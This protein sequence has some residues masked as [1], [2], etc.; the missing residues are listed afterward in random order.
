VSAGLVTAFAAQSRPQWPPAVQSVPDDSPSLSPDAEMRTFFLPPGYRVELVASEPMVEEPVLID[1]DPRGRMWVVEMLGYMQDMPATSEREPSGRISVLEDTNGDGRMDRKTVF[2][3]GL[4]LPRALK[5]LDRGVLVGEPPHLWLARD[6]NGD[7]KADQKDL[8]CD[9]YGT[10]LANVEHNL[11]GLLWAMDNWMHTAEGDVYLRLKDGTF[12]VRRTLSRGQWGVSQDDVGRIYRNNNSSALH[13]DLVP[14]PYYARHPTLLRTRGSFEFAGDPEEL[15]LVFPVRPNLINRGYVDGELRADGTLNRYT[16]VAAPTP[17]RGDR[18]PAELRGNIFVVEPSANLVSRIIVEDDGTRLRGRKAYPTAEFLTSTDERFR[19]VYLSSAPDG[20]IYIVDMYRGIIQHKGFI[21]EYLRDHIVAKQLETPTRKGRI[22]R[23]VHDST[24][25]DVR[26]ALAA[27]SSARLVERLSHP[28]GWWRDTAQRLLVERGDVSVV[29]AVKR[30]AEGSGDARTRLHALWTLD[31][32]DRIEPTTVVKALQAASRDVRVSGLRLA[33]RFLT[34]DPNPEVHAAVFARVDDVDWSVRQQLAASLGVLPSGP[35]ETAVAS[36][37][38]KHALDPVVV[39]AALS[40]LRGSESTVLSRVLDAPASTP[41]RETAITMLAGTIVR[42][43][44]NAPIQDVFQR[45]ADAARPSWQRAALLRGAEVA[46]MGAA[47][48]G[49]PSGRGRGR[50]S[51][52]G[53]APGQRGGPGGAPAFPP[54][55]GAA[56]PAAEPTPAGR[57]GGVRIG[58]RV[59]SEPALTGLAAGGGEF[60]ERATAL[61]ARIEWPGKP[62]AAAAAPP[63]TP[64]EEARFNAGR[65]VYQSLCQTCHQPDGRGQER[66]AASLLGSR[67]AL[68][69]PAIPVRILMNGKEGSTGLMPPLGSVLTDEQ[70][71]AV[72]TYLRRE[73]G[74]T[75]SP[76]DVRTVT[77]TRAL[78]TGR[79]RPWT[80]AELL[81]L[82]GK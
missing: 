71:A 36:L 63:L 19:P 72:L 17:Y 42:G 35:R 14:T 81:A 16:A 31:G 60:S 80:D 44:L 6:T 59:N 79:S 51:T 47:M 67:F 77:E 39:D 32:L 34:K 5:V 23:I 9:C 4:V 2:L 73:W 20:T 37:L 7:L 8:V 41:Q 15:N 22:F 64:E 29:G 57:G 74:H 24:R 38:E 1:W 53:T 46:L 11:N 52:E 10:A 18:L 45:A 27:E 82:I 69:P 70:I 62:G 56:P 50:A 68:A 75:A 3:D 58:L 13:V 33:E 25:R 21:T 30:L 66:L 43:G 54:A 78:T 65:T 48:P 49:S 55:R 61:L 40:G 76:V 26:P 12:E 28:N